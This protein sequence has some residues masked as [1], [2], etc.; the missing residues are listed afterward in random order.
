MSKKLIER[1]LSPENLEKARKAVE[2]NK[3][4]CGVDG[5]RVEKLEEYLKVLMIK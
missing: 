4:A 5:M 3:G 1:I 2:A